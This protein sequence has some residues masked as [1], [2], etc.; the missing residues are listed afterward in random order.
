MSGSTNIA[1]SG[2]ARAKYTRQLV[3]RAG[4]TW[5]LCSASAIPT[6][7]PIA[8]IETRD[9]QSP[10]SCLLSPV[11]SLRLRFLSRP[12]L[13]DFLGHL[14]AA[15]LLP[16]CDHLIERARRLFADDDADQR[17]VDHLLQ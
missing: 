7:F 15:Q 6:P 12:P 1:Y 8:W 10:I 4:A 17:L 9:Q 14:V 11:S 2:H 16:L 5:V 13:V 3:R